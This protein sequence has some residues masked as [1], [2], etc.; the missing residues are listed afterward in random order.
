MKLT[1]GGAPLP[2]DKEQDLAAMQKRLGVKSFQAQSNIRLI[3][4]VFDATSSMWNVWE[5]AKANMKKLVMRQRELTPNAEFILV[6]YRDY[7][8]GYRLLEISSPSANTDELI[9]FLDSI[10][11]S[12]GGDEPEA[13]EVALEQMIRIRLQPD[14]VILVGDAPPHG[15]ID[16]VV[17]G[18]DY[19]VYARKLGECKVP[20]YAISTNDNSGVTRSFQEIAQL[21][22][23]K[24]FLLNQVSDLIDLLSTATAK[25]A[26]QLGPLTDLLKRENGGRLTDRQERLLLEASSK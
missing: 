15:V 4:L 14:M 23:G 6:A 2:Q 5:E 3:A 24:Y 25:R 19:R 11:C 7:C 20:V 1:K 13:V 26:N 9:S 18:K 8:D 16:Q 21:T 22:G 17:N 12:G 10:R